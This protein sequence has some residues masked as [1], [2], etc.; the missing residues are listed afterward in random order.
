MAA[1]E[2]DVCPR[3][4]PLSASERSERASGGMS[5]W[6]C[7]VSEASRRPGLSAEHEDCDLDERSEASELTLSSRRMKDE[8]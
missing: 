6:A 4:P 1:H 7:K 2:D 3:I 8:A 5:D